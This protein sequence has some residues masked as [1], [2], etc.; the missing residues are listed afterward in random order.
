MI[1]LQH[2]VVIVGHT[3]FLRAWLVHVYVSIGSDNGEHV[4]SHYQNQ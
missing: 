3:L 1:L 2:D 4:T